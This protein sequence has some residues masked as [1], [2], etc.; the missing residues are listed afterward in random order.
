MALGNE[1]SRPSAANAVIKKQAGQNLN[2]CVRLANKQRV[3]KGQ[4]VDC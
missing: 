2:V 1:R 4:L 3:V